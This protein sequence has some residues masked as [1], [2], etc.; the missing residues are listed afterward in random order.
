MIKEIFS[1]EKMLIATIALKGGGLIEEIK[2]RDDVMLFEIT[3]KNRNSLLG[4][5][6]LYLKKSHA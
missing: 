3:Q 6:L 4:E 5:I 1:S 2:S